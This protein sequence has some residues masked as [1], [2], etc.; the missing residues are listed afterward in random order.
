MAEGGTGVVD[1]YSFEIYLS[2]SDS[3]AVNTEAA[4]LLNSLFEWVC[5]SLSPYILANSL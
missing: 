5:M 4:Q 2:T 3:A 1:F